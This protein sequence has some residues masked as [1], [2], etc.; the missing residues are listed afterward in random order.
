MP[1]TLYRFYN[2]LEKTYNNLNPAFLDIIV[3][4]YL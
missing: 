3:L 2:L 4:K 1:I